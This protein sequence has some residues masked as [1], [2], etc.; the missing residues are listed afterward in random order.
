[1]SLYEIN[2]ELERLC[3]K[4]EENGE[5]EYFDAIEELK[6]KR[7]EKITNV[8]LFI[9]NLREFENG[10][11]AEIKEFTA[12][13][14]AVA[15][16]IERL[17]SYLARCLQDGETF[18]NAKCELGWRSATSV[19]VPDPD[20]VPDSYCDFE[21][22]VRK[23]ELEHDLKLGADLPFARLVTKKHLQVK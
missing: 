13:K 18:E 22:V 21:R 8:A 3:A 17:K 20:L 12:R 16:K 15:N 11:A 14:K 19:E 10:L 4:L 7:D 23:K 5:A 9:K 2:K 1:M 6:L